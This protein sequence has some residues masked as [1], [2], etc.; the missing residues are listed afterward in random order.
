MISSQIL[1]VHHGRQSILCHV[2][3]INIFFGNSK[4][5]RSEAGVFKPKSLDFFKYL[6]HLQGV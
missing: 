6:G 3:I 2:N 4:G 1:K 5:S